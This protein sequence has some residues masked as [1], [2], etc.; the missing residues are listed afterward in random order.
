MIV[1]ITLSIPHG[2]YRVLE[3]SNV[4]NSS[5][6]TNSKVL[7]ET[8]INLYFTIIDLDLFNSLYTILIAYI[9]PFTSIVICYI[10]MI[11]KLRKEKPIVS[12]FLLYVHYFRKVSSSK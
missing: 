6:C 9:I 11:N 12:G 3:K 5:F 7:E 8:K 4:D 1:S 10:I 2:Y